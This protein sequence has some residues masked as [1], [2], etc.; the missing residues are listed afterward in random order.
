MSS[1]AS[2]SVR[3]I[4]AQK[5]HAKSTGSATV[6][7]DFLIGAYRY[8]DKSQYAREGFVFT[9]RALEYQ[10]KRGFNGVDRWA[11]TVTR[12]DE[13]IT[14]II[15]LPA[16]EK[17]NAQLVSARDHINAHGPIANVRLTRTGSAYYFR[18]ERPQRVG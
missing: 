3:R 18:P 4:N 12:L 10:P 9:I 2:T 17:R 5:R 16:N 13:D 8:A 6:D 11:A 15:T 1:N 14:E 7:F